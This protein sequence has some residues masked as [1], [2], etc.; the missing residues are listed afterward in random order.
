MAL[1]TFREI[2]GRCGHVYAP[3]DNQCIDCGV[4]LPARPHHY[5]PR[6]EP[7][8]AAIDRAMDSAFDAVGAER[9]SKATP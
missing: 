1:R 7:L 9:P 3:L 5:W 6:R 8:A 4:T 2:V